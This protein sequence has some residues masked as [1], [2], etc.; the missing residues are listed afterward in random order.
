MTSCREEVPWKGQQGPGGAEV[1]KTYSSAGPAAAVWGAGGQARRGRS[2]ETP[3]HCS[4]FCDPEGPS[5]D[6]GEVQSP[7][8]LARACGLSCHV[9]SFPGQVH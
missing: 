4:S 8:Q 9:L 3:Q 5:R 7:G 1:G 2:T 6:S